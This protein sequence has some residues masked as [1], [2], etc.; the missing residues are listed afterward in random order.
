MEER[1]KQVLCKWLEIDLVN[2]ANKMGLSD[3]SCD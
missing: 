3:E 1:K 2:I